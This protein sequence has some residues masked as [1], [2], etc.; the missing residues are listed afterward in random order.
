MDANNLPDLSQL[1]FQLGDLIMPWLM[2]LFSL[3]VIVW[4]K[5]VVE[6]VVRG[7]LFQFDKS[8]NEG[9][10]VILDNEPAT[11]IKIGLSN[12]VFGVYSD[13][14]YTWRYVP[15]EMI[16]R[17]K[18]EKVIDKNLHPDSVEEQGARIQRL[19][20]AAQ[21]DS[22]SKNK[23]ASVRNAKAIE[24]LKNGNQTKKIGK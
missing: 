23:T 4:V 18:L 19:I 14:G 6:S 11:I 10:H 2:V 15:N 9:D 22:I 17:L 21:D 5:N 20:D 1:S 24:E 3:I 16:A 7:L 12:T 13:R 8:F